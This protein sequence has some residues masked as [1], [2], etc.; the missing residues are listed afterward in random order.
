MQRRQLRRHTHPVANGMLLL[1]DR[2]DTL[3]QEYEIGCG[4]EM[5]DDMDKDVATLL[6]LDL[7]YYGVVD[8]DWDNEWKSLDDYLDWCKEW[9]VKSERVLKSNGS[10]Y[11]FNSQFKVMAAIDTL[12][13]SCTALKFRQFVTIDKGLQS[14]A[15]RTSDALRTY[16]TATE[17]FN[18]Y[19]FEDF[20]GVEMLSDEIASNN[21]FADKIRSARI[22]DGLSIN[23]VA[24]HGHFYGKINHGGSVTN[25]EKGYNIPSK[26]QWGKLCQCLPSLKGGY[27]GLVDVFENLKNEYEDLRKEYEDLRYPFNSM[28]GFT[29]VWQFNFYKDKRNG[30][31][32]QKPFDLIER[33]VLTSSNIGDLVVDPAMGS[34]TSYKV[35]KSHDRSFIGRELN[36]KYEK[37]II[38][39]AMPSTPTIGSYGC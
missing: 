16:P 27:N 24:E 3:K 32:T 19:T 11:Y 4:L 18:F 9:F 35:C 33:I 14:V 21:P 10:L 23:E 8:A 22:E 37:D 7:P 25:W 2:S 20:T 28:T 30:H 1:Y 13:E 38:S 31:P 39:H 36:Q 34:G 5:L 26:E 29:D 17:Y 6:I 12:I 15:G